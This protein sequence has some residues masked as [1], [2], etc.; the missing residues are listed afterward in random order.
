MHFNKLAADSV[1][2]SSSSSS[3]SSKAVA[4]AIALPPSSKGTA[5][6]ALPAAKRP[7]VASPVELPL[8]GQVAQLKAQLHSQKSRIAQLEAQLE[9]Q[10]KAQKALEAKSSVLNSKLMSIAKIA[11]LDKPEKMKGR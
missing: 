10:L 11:A 9:A 1:G 5:G 4:L 3:S 7:R 2:S 8:A 6:G